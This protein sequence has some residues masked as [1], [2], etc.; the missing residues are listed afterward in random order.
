[1]HHVPDS[2]HRA[3]HRE[4]TWSGRFLRQP[5]HQ[6]QHAHTC[7]IKPARSQDGR[8]KALKT[9][10][11]IIDSSRIGLLARGNDRRKNTMPR[12][13]DNTKQRQRSISLHNGEKKKRAVRSCLRAPHIGSDASMH[14]ACQHDC[15]VCS[16]TVPMRISAPLDNGYALLS[17]CMALSRNQVPFVEGCN[18]NGRRPGA[19]RFEVGTTVTLLQYIQIS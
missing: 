13:Y 5:S 7:T 12:L 14:P 8:S 16:L 18:K 19:A 10:K 2:S 3:L 17:L 6:V 4:Y 11:C 1:M 15:S 9:H